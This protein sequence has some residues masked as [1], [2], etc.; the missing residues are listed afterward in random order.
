MS[1]VFQ[2]DSLEWQVL[3]PEMTKEVYA[4]LMLADEVKVMLVRVAPGGGFRSHRDGYGHLFYFLSGNG[5]V[6]VGESEHAA[7]TGLVV[8]V[9]AGE[10][11]SYENTGETDLTLLSINV[12]S[13]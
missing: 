10:P 4:K 11:H 1:E 5:V 3:R 13:P 9:T 6:R 2:M 12:P 8:Q 7:R